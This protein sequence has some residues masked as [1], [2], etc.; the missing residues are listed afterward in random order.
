[1]FLPAEI[2]RQRH[3][4]SLDNFPVDPEF[5]TDGRVI[6]PFDVKVPLSRKRCFTHET[7]TNVK[8][9]IFIHFG[10]TDI[11]HGIPTKRGTPVLPKFTRRNRVIPESITPFGF[12][13]IKRE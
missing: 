11:A 5:F 10:Q 12:V 8:E 4:R 9:A 2:L 3:S 13:L 1:M 6:I 7:P